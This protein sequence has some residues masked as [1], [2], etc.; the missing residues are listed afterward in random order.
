MDPVIVGLQLIIAGAILIVRL[1]RR[2]SR[3]SGD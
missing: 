3:R 2:R 1:K